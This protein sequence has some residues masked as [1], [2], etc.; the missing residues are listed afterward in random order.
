M[1]PLS[2]GINPRLLSHRHPLTRRLE[3]GSQ[4][5]EHRAIIIILP[6]GKVFQL[7]SEA[8]KAVESVILLCRCTA[9]LTGHLWHLVDDEI[10]YPWTLA[11]DF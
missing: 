1:A 6:L 8:S 10:A 7:L 2:P 9:T 4:P 11:P 3:F 5:S